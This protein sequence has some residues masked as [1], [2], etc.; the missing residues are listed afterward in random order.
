MNLKKSDD[1]GAKVS[2]EAQNAAA[3]KAHPLL[4]RLQLTGGQSLSTVGYASVRDTDAIN[5]LI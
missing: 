1:A 5:K 2:A 4:A 3:I